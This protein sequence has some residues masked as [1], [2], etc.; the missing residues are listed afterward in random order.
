MKKLLL[1]PAL[2]AL[3]CSN[4]IYAQGWVTQ[5]SGV[6]AVSLASVNFISATT[7]LAVGT[8]GTI[9]KT[10]NGG[11]T[12]SAR[13]SLTANA[14][15]SVVFAT[16]TNAY[17]VGQFGIILMSTNAG[18]NWTSQTT[19]TNLTSV[20]FSSANT[21][22]AVGATGTILKTTNGGT[23]W[24]ALTS[25]TT[26]NLTCVFFATDLEGYVT[27]AAGRIQKTTNGG[28]NWTLL[29]SGVTGTI[30]SVNFVSTTLGWACGAAGT[31]L[32]TTNGGTNWVSQ[33][34][35]TNTANITCVNFQNVST[36]WATGQTGRINFT[37]NSGNNWST[38]TSG[39][40]SNLT[41]IYMVN[42]TTGWIV[43]DNGTI[44][45]TTTGGLS[46]PTAPVLTAPANNSSNIST[47]P[48]F[49]WNAVNG[50][51]SYKILISTVSNFG[52]ITDSAIVTTNSYTIAPGKLQNASAYFWK[53]NASN[54]VGTSAYSTTFN[55][56]TTLTPPPTPTLVSPANGAAGQSLT[57]ALVWQSLTGITSFHIEVST[58]SNFALITDSG[59]VAGSATQYMVPAGKLSV[60]LTYFWRVR[61]TNASG[62]GSYTSPW[63]FSTL[64]TGINLISSEIPKEFKLFGNYPNP[65][66]P[67]TKIKFNIPEAGFA[68]LKIY[69]ASG[70][71]VSEVF[72]NNF[73]AGSYE[74]EWQGSSLA[75]GVYFYRFES[76]S[77]SDTKRM[78][79]IK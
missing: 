18:D 13:S 47:T 11:T 25:G 9:I 27:G 34:L 31:M 53:V 78:M 4:F 39:T 2:F 8:G 66:N 41:S 35:G 1:I 29:T 59:T 71:L 12:W 55:F 10:T 73:A 23:N 58:L 72:N 28:T 79:L 38:Q 65:F 21:G 76:A 48:T 45:K 70:K 14:L 16:P 62:T 67:T 6:G 56:S 7:G 74:V 20:C 19:G 61:A 33:A 50:A 64:L 57:P 3:L 17:A 52:I 75:S 46:V 60:G 68:S 77:F 40:N 32:N 63:S 49:T 54:A 44:L 15:T 51:A 37:A 24:T 43:G 36:G 42:T 5:T 22:Y 30:N 26:A 69:N